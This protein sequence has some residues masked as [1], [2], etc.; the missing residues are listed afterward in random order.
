MVLWPG[1]QAYLVQ[2]S[3]S[4]KNPDV[5]RRKQEERLMSDT[6]KWVDHLWELEFITAIFTWIFNFLSRVAEP[7]MTLAVI[8]TII[9]AGIPHAY[10]PALYNTAIAAMIGSPESILPGA[11]ILAGQ[12]QR[13][14]NKHAWMLLAICGLFVLLTALTLSDLFIFHFGAQG[15]SILMCARC[16]AGVS[17]SIIIRIVHHQGSSEP[18][19]SRAAFDAQQFMNQ[20]LA[21]VDH[22]NQQAVHDLNG[23]QQEFMNQVLSR[24]DHMNQQVAHDLNN[25]HQ[26]FMNQ[27]EQATQEAVNQATFQMEQASARCLEQLATALDALKSTPPGDRLR[28]LAPENHEHTRQGSQTRLHR[29]EKSP[30]PQVHDLE[31]VHEMSL[32]SK[33]HKVER[34][35]RE[36]VCAFIMNHCREQRSKPK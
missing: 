15:V 35:N 30:G 16:V 6:R 22:M 28:L 3:K 25:S 31:R 33:V 5:S 7:L 17:Y 34:A 4:Q 1:Q 9:V 2:D 29:E 32:A 14:G 21:Q 11:F 10:Q 19:R 36:Q 13:S 8:Y 12:E 20:I 18:A 23:S 26:A 24:V 27:T